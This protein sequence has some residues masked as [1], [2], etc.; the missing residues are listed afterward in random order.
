MK[1]FTALFCSIITNHCFAE[2]LWSDFSA[3]LLKGNH[4]QVGDNNR[5]VFTFEHAAGYSWGDSFLFIDRLQSNNGNKETY[6]EIAPRFQLSG[7]QNRLIKNIYLATT[8]EIGDS[9][10]HYLYGVGTQLKI[11]N[12]KYFNI[13]LY[14]RNNNSGDNSQQITLTW[15]LPINQ[16]LYDGFIDFVP[17]SDDKSTS[18]NFTS[19]LKYNLA[20]HFNLNTK[21]YVGVEYNYWFNKFGI[22]GIDEKNLN[23]LFKYHF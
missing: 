9:F 21:L 19:Q 23:L 17:S 22:E 18:L 20:E 11:P 16:L 12:F 1:Y 14:H 8:I 15:A 3:S 2:T 4:Y 5:T 7:Y 13:N 10:T 6:A